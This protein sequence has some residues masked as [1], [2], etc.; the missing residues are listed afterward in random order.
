[1]ITCRN[2]R[3]IPV[4][5]YGNLT[6]MNAVLYCKREISQY[7]L[8]CGEVFMKSRYL[9]VVLLILLTIALVMVIP[10]AATKS[11]EQSF[12]DTLTRGSR[13]TVTITGLPNTSYYIWLPRT[14]TMTGEPGNQP[15]YIADSLLNVMKDPAGGPYPIGSYQYNNG[16]G[17]TIRDD[18]APSTATMPNI[19]YYALVRTNDDGQAVVEFQT[20]LNTGLRSYS[21]RVE[22]PGSV[23]SDNLLVQIRVFSRKATSVTIITP[24]STSEPVVTPIITPILTSPQ[25]TTRT[26]EPAIFTVQPTRTPVP[27]TKA[28]SGL[29]PVACALIVS[30][31]LRG[32]GR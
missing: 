10:V 29:F 21:V 27:T 2:K 28:A 6:G 22:N 1:M 15:P 18:V 14:F 20:S 24:E 11:V 16:N 5:R 26:A 12:S 19:N 25:A 17:R 9:S 4:Y 30:G 8:Y 23:D 31:L 32:R 3:V 7:R 13:F